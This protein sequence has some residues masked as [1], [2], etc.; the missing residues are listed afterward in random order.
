MALPPVE[1]NLSAAAWYTTYGAS[2]DCECLHYVNHF[3][4]AQ[5]TRDQ[6]MSIPIPSTNQCPVRFLQSGSN[7]KALFLEVCG[8]NH[9]EGQSRKILTS[10]L[11]HV[12]QEQMTE[13][14]RQSE[15]FL[16]QSETRLKPF[17]HISATT[18]SSPVSST[19]VGGKQTS[20]SPTM[21]QTQPS[22]HIL[23]SV[24]LIP[25]LSRPTNSL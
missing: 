6:S 11:A 4:P 12:R 20:N 13:D 9:Q 24:H 8:L 17:R 19:A 18:S 3:L 1:S 2:A 10:H 21:G 16:T 22:S 25:T 15:L 14:S 7:R 23:H 5:T